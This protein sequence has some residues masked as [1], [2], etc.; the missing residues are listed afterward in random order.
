[1][2]MSSFNR[3]SEADGNQFLLLFLY[4]QFIWIVIGVF[5]FGVLNKLCLTYVMESFAAHLRCL[6]YSELSQYS[7]HGYIQSF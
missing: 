2:L 5:I 6:F 7:L 4:I 1:M 3:S